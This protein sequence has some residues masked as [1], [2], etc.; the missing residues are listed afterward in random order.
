[1]LFSRKGKIEK[2]DDERGFTLLE[3]FSSIL[4]EADQYT[5]SSG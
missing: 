4:P 5:Q 2:G 1:L 3:R